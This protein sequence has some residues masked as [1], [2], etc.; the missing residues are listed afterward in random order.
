MLALIKLWCRPYHLTEALCKVT[1][2]REPNR[3][4]DLRDSQTV[5]CQKT[6]R[7]DDSLLLDVLMRRNPFGEMKRLDEMAPELMF[8]QS[9]RFP[10]RQYRAQDG[11]E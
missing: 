2:V 7:F 3:K 4:G 5:L 9:P 6:S 10:Q 1:L 8:A 11:P